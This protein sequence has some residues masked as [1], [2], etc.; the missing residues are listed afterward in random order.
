MT[1]KQPTQRL[2]RLRVRGPR[3]GLSRYYDYIQACLN[4]L[5]LKTA[6]T[7]AYQT[8]DTVSRD[9]FADFFTHGKPKPVIPKLIRQDIGYKALVRQGIASFVHGS[10]LAVFFK[11]TGIQHKITPIP[12]LW[13]PTI[14]VN[15]KA[16]VSGLLW[17]SICASKP[18][19]S[20]GF[21]A[22][23]SL[24]REETGRLARFLFGKRF[25]SRSL[26][27]QRFKL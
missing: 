13:V 9:A 20:D 4:P 25:V 17:L 22:S 19:V 8:P 15:I 3:G 11:R 10:E 2:K 12:V 18:F 5:G 23:T 26:T 7:L 16:H 27:P 6:V 1:R 24:S 14:S 21:A